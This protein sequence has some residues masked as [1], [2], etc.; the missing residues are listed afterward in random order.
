AG[1][2]SRKA[3]DQDDEKWIFAR[4]VRHLPEGLTFIVDTPFGQFPVN[5]PLIGDFNVSN[6]LAAAGAALARRI[7]FHA[8]QQGVAVTRSISGRMERIDLG[9]RFTVIVDFA[10][11]P[12]ALERALETVRRLTTG[13]VIVVFG[14]AGLRDVQK[15]PWMGNVAGRLAD[16]TVVTAEDPRTESLD[17]IN[18]AIAS[19]LVKAGRQRD[20]DY[21]IVNDRGEAIRFAIGKLARPGDLVIITG[22]G[23]ERSMCFGKTEYPW[24]DQEAVIAA[25]KEIQKS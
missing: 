21:Y 19:G 16:L 13:R 10:H 2:D 22:K 20:R 17:D 15:R 18:A 25:L 5:S 8:I 24:S 4:Q 9:Q 11:T 23:H 6:I 3:K 7:P 12:N 14:T 1:E